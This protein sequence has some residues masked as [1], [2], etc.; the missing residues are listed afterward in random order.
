MTSWPN[1]EPT[2]NLVDLMHFS[3]SAMTTLESAGLEPRNGL[4]E[5]VAGSQALLG[6][7]LTGLLGFVVANRIRRS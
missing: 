3:L 2:R 5:L 1:E 4:V 6:I 7:A